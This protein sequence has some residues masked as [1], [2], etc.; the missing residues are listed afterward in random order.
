M[1]RQLK[2]HNILIN[3]LSVSIYKGEYEYLKHD[4]ISL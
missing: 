2:I 1:E 3:Y 4:E